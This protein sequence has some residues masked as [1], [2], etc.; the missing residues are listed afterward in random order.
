MHYLPEAHV[1]LERELSTDE[2][3]WCWPIEITKRRRVVY[4]HDGRVLLRDEGIDVFSLAT[5]AH[6]RLVEITLVL[7]AALV[8][9]YLL[10]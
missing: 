3:E 2:R 8:L 10:R 1:R 9:V 4:W 5:S 6:L 7:E